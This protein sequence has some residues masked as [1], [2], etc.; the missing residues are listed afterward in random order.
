LDNLL[1]IFKG[2]DTI[3]FA[4]NVHRN[5]GAGDNYGVRLIG[6]PDDGFKRMTLEENREM[7]P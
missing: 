5:E 6:Y 4:G 7:N 3:R 2:S 1:G